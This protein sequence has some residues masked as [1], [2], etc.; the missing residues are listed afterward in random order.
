DAKY[1]NLVSMIQGLGAMHQP[2]LPLE[3]EVNENAEGKDDCSDE[4]V[5]NWAKAVSAVDGGPDSLPGGEADVERQSHFDRPL[6]EIRVGESP[7][8]PWGISVPIPDEP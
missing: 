5:Q 2:L 3:E 6:K 1:G 8:R 7:S 4:R